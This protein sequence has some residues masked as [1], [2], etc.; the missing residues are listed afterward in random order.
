MLP[1]RLLTSLR[2]RERNFRNCRRAD[3]GSMSCPPLGGALDAGCRDVR[4]VQDLSHV[5]RMTKTDRYFRS[6][7][8][9]YWG[10]GRAGQH[11]P[12]ELLAWASKTVAL[13]V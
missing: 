9:E 11:S 5:L 2:R 6:R 8:P 7:E 4:I 12:D 1:I 13:A 3:V 10:F